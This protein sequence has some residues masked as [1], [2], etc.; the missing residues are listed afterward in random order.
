MIYADDTVLF[1][2][3]KVVSSIENNLNTDL[4]SLQ[5]QLSKNELLINLKK[6]KTEP[7]LFGSGKHL[8]KLQDQTID[9]SIN[10]IPISKT[11]S[12]K[13]LGVTIDPTLNF[14][15]NFLNSCKK[16]SARARLLQKIRSSLNV[17]SAESIYQ[18]M[19]MPI[20]MYCN[21]VLLSYCS[22]KMQKIQ[23]LEYIYIRR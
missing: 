18:S 11:K 8:S 19:I 4:S 12:H 2:A 1:T 9:V 15:E 22:A 13:Y 14:Q 23:R 17:H 5:S 3:S 6:G 7:M 10:N 20:V 16:V 21:S